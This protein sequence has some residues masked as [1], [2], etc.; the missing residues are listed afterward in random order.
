MPELP[1]LYTTARPALTVQITPLVKWDSADVG[2]GVRARFD[3]L[4]YANTGFVSG[5][6]TISVALFGP[7]AVTLV[8]LRKQVPSN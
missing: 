8:L 2:E 1:I 4:P 3:T 7:N 5:V 6:A